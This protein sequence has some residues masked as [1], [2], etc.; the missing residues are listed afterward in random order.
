MFIFRKNIFALILI[1]SFVLF[2]AGSPF[3]QATE[4]EPER[5]L[6]VEYPLIDQWR[7]ETVEQAIF[8]QYIKYIFTFSIAI[9][10]LVA[11]GALI[12]GGFRY[13][14]SAGAPTT[15]TE[16]K[17][18][19]FAGIIG[20]VILL[21]SYLILTTI[22]PQLVLL[23]SPKLLRIKTTEIPGVYLSTKQKF[24]T[25]EEIEAGAKVYLLTSSIDDLSTMVDGEIKSLKIVNRYKIEKEEGEPIE[26]LDFY[27]GVILHSNKNR[28]GFCYG[29][30]S[31]FGI[32]FDTTSELNLTPRSITVFQEVKPEEAK[33]EVKLCSKPEVIGTDEEEKYCKS[34]EKDELQ[35][36]AEPK[37]LGEL[38]EKVWSIG[39]DGNYLVVLYDNKHNWCTAFDSS[40][41]NLKEYLINK[42]TPTP[43]SWL[44]TIYNSCATH[45]LLFPIKK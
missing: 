41:A 16:A 20:L 22:N 2:L 9:A 25:D 24:P 17:D 43:I 14:T 34:L 13:I 45:Y 6:E 38:Q 36:T 8:P 1:T 32:G 19:I 4:E 26:K 37:G 29:I 21:S 5:E 40:V 3:I 11:F 10:G 35:I 15:Q 39:I 42:C 44:F 18:Q 33:G 7:P 12:Y 23:K 28:E 27:Y 31:S 30:L